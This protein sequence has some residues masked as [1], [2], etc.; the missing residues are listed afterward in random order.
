M[1]INFVSKIKKIKAYYEDSISYKFACI[2]T[3]ISRFDDFLE[4]LVNTFQMRNLETQLFLRILIAI[5]N[6]TRSMKLC[7]VSYALHSIHI[8]ATNTIQVIEFGTL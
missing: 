2:L 5:I 3:N 8:I 1:L 6:N 4:L 7:I